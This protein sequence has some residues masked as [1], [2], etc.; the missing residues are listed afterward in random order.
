MNDEKRI[1]KWRIPESKMSV[2]YSYCHEC[3]AIN[4]QKHDPDCKKPD[5]VTRIVK[6]TQFGPCN[7]GTWCRKLREKMKSRGVSTY[8]SPPDDTGKIALFEE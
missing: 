6:T 8:I 7:F 5:R 3:Q 4:D 2:T 1:T